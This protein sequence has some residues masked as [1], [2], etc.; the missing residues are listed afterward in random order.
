MT[1]IEAGTE[2]NVW[3]NDPLRAGDPPFHVNGILV[4]QSDEAV[5]GSY[6]VLHETSMDDTEFSEVRC[7]PVDWITQLEEA[8]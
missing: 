6:V 7:I 4:G 1:D 2:I 8:P 3:Y 5:E